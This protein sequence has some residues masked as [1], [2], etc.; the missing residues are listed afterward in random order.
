MKLLVVD[1]NPDI[2][3]ILFSSL[4]F[5][6]HRVD[7]ACDGVDAVNFLS[8]HRYD[9]VITDADMPRMDGFRLCRT[10]KAQFPDIKVI[11]LSGIWGEKA[12]RNAGADLCLATP[13]SI[14]DLQKA[15]ESICP[16]SVAPE[17]GRDA[18]QEN[19]LMKI[20]LI[21]ICLVF[22][23][24]IGMAQAAEPKVGFIKNVSGEASIE[25]DKVAVSAKV[26][27]DVMEKDTLITG[28][29]GS[30]GI[31]LQDNSVMSVGPDTRVVISE[32]AFDP[33]NE[34]L[35]LIAKIQKGIVVYLSGL[36][37]KLKKG[38]VKFETNSSVCAIRGTRLAIR[39]DDAGK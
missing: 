28:N 23:C 16:A 11:G 10:I 29:G 22:A 4:K 38:A 17:A 1:D 25:R 27:D 30:M 37:A 26:K 5:C 35:S 8:K 34:K 33:A 21:T 18:T 7:R 32:F 6:G 12:F 20:S 19:Q 39:V 36:I 24:C 2:L 31:I 15:V 3:E 14:I 9:V 13:F